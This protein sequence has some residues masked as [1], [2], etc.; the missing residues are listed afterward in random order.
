MINKFWKLARKNFFFLFLSFQLR[1]WQSKF[2]SLILGKYVSSVLVES[3]GYKFLVHPG[4]MAV[5]RTLINKGVYSDKE[6][7][8][9]KNLVDN[10]STVIF[11]GCHI[12][13]LSIPIAK[14]VSKIYMIEA[15][16]FTYD[17]LEKNIKL[18][19]INNSI[20]IETAASDENGETEFLQ[21]IVNSGGS[22]I[23]PKKLK[24]NY[25]YDSPRA[26]TVKKSRIDDL[27]DEPEVSLIFMDI[28]GSEYFALKG[29][30]NLLSKCKVLIIEFLPD[31]LKNV[32]GVSVQ[33][34][35]KQLSSHFDNLEIK[36]LNKFYH[37]KNFNTPLQYMFDNNI[38]SEGLIF[39]KSVQ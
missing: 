22:K 3:K 25:I 5:G 27:I 14:H 6:L 4:D 21:N 15:N 19:N 30:Q 18:N 8:I 24:Y 29:M 12:G 16:P 34:F 17:L 11:I 13:S 31:H 26:T 32:S 39:S 36:E 33:E 20:L 10:K 1:K 23:K 28:E 7:S 9:I 38:S 35:V 37:N 2:I